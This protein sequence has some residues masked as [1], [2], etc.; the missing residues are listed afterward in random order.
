MHKTDR[1][2][3]KWFLIVLCSMVAVDLTYQVAANDCALKTQ[4]FCSHFYD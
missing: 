3:I 4:P 1:T 2:I